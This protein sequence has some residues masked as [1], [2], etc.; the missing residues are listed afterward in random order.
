MTAH[1]AWV[2]VDCRTSPC[3]LPKSF[4]VL[5]SFVCSPAPVVRASLPG[6][7]RRTLRRRQ[8]EISTIVEHVDV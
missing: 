1:G 2:V 7:A 4:S 3:F 6:Q 5:V 8:L